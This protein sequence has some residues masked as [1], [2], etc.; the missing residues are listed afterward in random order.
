MWPS[1]SSRTSRPNET[2]R[3]AADGPQTLSRRL[4]RLVGWP[5]VVAILFWAGATFIVWSG[6]ERM[7]YYEGMKLAQPVF[8]RVRFEQ[9]NESRTAERRKKTQQD[10][11]NYFRLNQDLVANIKSALQDLHAAVKGAESFDEYQE[12]HG[13]DRPLE[14]VVFEKLKSLT[15]EAGSEQFKQKMDGL[16]GRLAVENM[17]ERAEMDLGRDVR[18][19][20]S[21]VM[22]DRGT[23]KFSAVRKE[24]L[25]Y[26]SNPDHVRKLA[27]DL[28]QY[29]F[30]PD[31]KEAM[32]P[33]VERAIVP[34]PK[35][36]RPVYVFD[37]EATKARIDQEL[38]KLEP[39][40]DAY[41]P[42]GELVKAG[43]LND[44]GLALLKAEQTEYLRQREIDPELRSQCRKQR[45]G[46][47]GVMLFITAGLAIY[48]ART[49]PRVL[50]KPAR[51]VAFAALLLVMLL[52]D[53]LV[54]G[55]IGSSPAW[56][57]AT[58]AMTAA[59][60]TIAYSQ[61]FALGATIS[62]ALL[63]VVTIDAPLGILVIYLTVAAATVMLLR[64][65][66]TRLKMVLAGCQTAALAFVSAVFVG[67]M[68]QQTLPFILTQAG[69]A[70]FAAMGGI[71]LVLVLLPVIERVFRITTSLTLLEWADTSNALL[72]QLIEKAPGTWQ[73]SHLLG[74]MAE[75]AAEEIEANGLLVRVG[76]YYHDIGKLC[77]SNYFVENQQARM[78][79][80]R[81]LAPT[82]SL[83]VI[84]THVKDGVALA[85]EHHLPPVLHQFIAEHH[86]TTIVKYF[87]AIAEKEAR[88]TGRREI[89]DTEFR[90]PG[91]KPSSRES[92]I[93]MLGD[94]VEGAVRALQD[95]TPGRIEGV[96]HEMTMNRL[97][98]GQFDDCDITLKELSRIEQSLVKSLRAIYHGRIAYPDKKDGGQPQSQPQIRSA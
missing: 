21:E 96:V 87:H 26:A 28:V 36:H 58:I 81:G 31:L 71:S 60:L 85:R 52:L 91:P 82:M 56:S 55:Q 9:I 80:H 66:R 69:F 34:Q 75:A 83:L 50:Y 49:Q 19:T 38:A 29:L 86:G 54:L 23:D 25:T 53:R 79:A 48:T 68:G 24:R 84:L 32:V 37:R 46:L 57:V 70:A 97:M 20:A 73:H 27:E 10:V 1:R 12:A 89:S 41:E 64:E 94:G 2:R 3:R 11:P 65:F 95:P 35:E 62:L 98:D 88:A 40:R 18:S 33:L 77:K 5:L 14:A 22:L 72:R 44:Q 45:L 15:D 63:T 39:V 8:S 67:L 4:R 43:L 92:A 16:A 6:D 51:A 17:I 59:V 13:L 76:A 42:G 90:Y 78:N 61:R 74:S 47:L 7:P 30:S 93:L